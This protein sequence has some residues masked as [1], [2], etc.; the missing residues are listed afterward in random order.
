MPVQVYVKSLKIVH[1]CTS[2][3]IFC[4][5]VIIMQLFLYQRYW[6]KGIYLLSTDTHKYH[7]LTNAF[8]RKLNYRKKGAVA[9]Q[10]QLKMR[11]E[12]VLKSEF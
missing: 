7:K 10:I 11:Q 12:A 4:Y 5:V 8:P 2:G 9:N 3:I 6:I 1:S